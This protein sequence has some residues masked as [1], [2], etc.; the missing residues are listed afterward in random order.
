VKYGIG[1]AKARQ[2]TVNPFPYIATAQEYRDTQLVVSA[3]TEAL[4]EQIANETQENDQPE[5]I[6][7]TQ[8]NTSG[9]T[10]KSSTE[11]DSQ[12]QK[13]TTTSKIY[14]H[15]T[16]G[17][18]VGFENKRSF[19][20][21]EETVV[22]VYINDENLIVSNGIDLTSTLR[23][24]AKVTPS[25]LTTGDFSDG[26][27]EVKVKT[28]SNSTFKIV[29]TGDFGEVRSLSL[30][31]SLFTDVDYSDTHGEAI[32]YLKENNIVGGYPDGSFKP[33]GTL[34]RAEAVKILLVGNKIQAQVRN[35]SFPDVPADSWFLPYVTTAASRGI[36]K[37][38]TDGEFK[39]GNTISR[40]EFLKVAIKTAGFDPVPPTENPYSD[41]EKD[42]WFAPYVAFSKEQDLIDLKQGGYWVPSQPITRGEAATVIYKL[43]KIK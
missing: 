26:V 37:G 16:N 12:E 34:N 13:E 38:Y 22:Q 25:K 6:A 10:E 39:P 36:V 23:H 7:S 8:E 14:S 18:V 35:N 19:V 32:A 20:P 41:V 27:A 30:R 31:A 24:L 17:E 2:Y 3:D 28:D 42:Q 29:A 15:D 4:S 33:G 9:Q 40:A 43:S 11:G 5:E 1:K 21:G